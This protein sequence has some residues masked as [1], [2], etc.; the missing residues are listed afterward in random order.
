AQIAPPGYS[1]HKRLIVRF[2]ARSKRAEEIRLTLSQ[3]LV[4]IDGWDAD[5]DLTIWSQRTIG[6]QMLRHAAV[7]PCGPFLSA[8]R[9]ADDA[10]EARAFATGNSH[11]HMISLSLPLGHIVEQQFATSAFNPQRRRL[12]LRSGHGNREITFGRG[13]CVLL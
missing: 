10:R 7:H 1:T 2:S 11:N 6:N 13:A 12:Q 8:P 9:Q 5:D 4:C 3:H